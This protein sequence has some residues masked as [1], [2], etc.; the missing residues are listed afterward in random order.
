MQTHDQ[1]TCELFEQALRLPPEQRTAYLASACGGDA[2]LR[3]EV[4]SLLAH[5]A[6]AEGA[7]MAAE[8]SARRAGTAHHSAQPPNDHPDM[9]L[10]QHFGRYFIRGV[11]GHGGMGTV[12][13]AEQEHPHRIVALK[14]MRTIFASPAALRRFEREAEL[15]GR[16]QHPGIAQV[17][18]ADIADT[19]HGRLPF[20][21]MELV[22]G[23]Q[24]IAQFAGG[25]GVS[26]VVRDQGIEGSRDREREGTGNRE[27][28]TERRVG[29]AHHSP[30]TGEDA[31][32]WAMLTLHASRLSS[33]GGT[34]VSP[35]NCRSRDGRDAHPTRA[36]LP[37][38]DR[39]EL[40]ARVCDA[41]QHGHLN[42]VIHRDL[43]PANILVDLDGNPKIIDFGVARVLDRE[44]TLATDLTGVGQLVGTVHYMSPEQFAGDPLRVDTR[45]DVYSL[46]VVLYELLTGR[47]PHLVDDSSIVGLSA[48]ARMV[49]DDPPPRPAQFNRH[50]RRP[51]EAV[52]LKALSRRPED[53]YSSAGDLARDVRRFLAGEPTEAHPPGIAA[54][55]VAWAVKHPVRL[56][57]GLSILTSILL[58]GAPVGGFL[59]L[60]NQPGGLIL[61]KG[62]P[63]Q[64]AIVFSRVGEDLRTFQGISDVRNELPIIEK[65]ARPAHWGGGFLLVGCHSDETTNWSHVPLT[66][67]R[68][69]GRC[70]RVEWARSLEPADIPKQLAKR[71]N[72]EFT[73]RQFAVRNVLT[74]DVFA[75]DMGPG[76]EGREIITC[77]QHMRTHAALCIYNV[78]GD[79]LYMAWL[80][81]QVDDLLWAQ[82][83]DHSGEPGLLLVSGVHG[84]HTLREHF[85]E[86]S[87][88]HAAAVLA[89]EPRLGVRAAE[90]V[91][92]DSPD[93]TL[94]PVWLK[95]VNARLGARPSNCFLSAPETVN[96]PPDGCCAAINF[97]FGTVDAYQET[98]HAVWLARDG[99]VIAPRTPEP[100]RLTEARMNLPDGHPAKIWPP[101]YY[102]LDDQVLPIGQNTTQP[103][104]ASKP[105]S[106]PP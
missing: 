78:K 55:M 7:F 2:A 60:R 103:A 45:S 80:E 104:P 30:Q 37:L 32:R 42:G 89:V 96:L 10:G 105:H 38:R 40:F 61:V 35:A 54:R 24:T 102:T 75:P 97:Q 66:A 93:P 106:G 65:V 71:D 9:L 83:G 18:E 64:H 73:P 33:A 59:Y 57:A 3:A 84:K 23:A 76:C 90:Y 46:G 1:R 99:S 70:D 5:D 53:R 77:H 82:A 85:G 44:A 95:F 14:V 27:Q 4:E 98:P 29:R 94:R 100:G 25:T 63:V 69:Q 19:P 26:P 58:I 11:I 79:L 88:N 48:L 15:L 6:A 72:A 34:G 20:F 56:T 8:P 16:L 49:R 52:M 51:L 47:R 91:S 41:V 31:N 17:F 67:W 21:A 92:P 22:R 62:S 101:E 74:A 68:W 13:E 43:K 28:G 86:K 87:D 39:L 50:I 36:P 12:Y 81:F